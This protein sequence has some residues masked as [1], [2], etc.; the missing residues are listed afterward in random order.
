MGNS[1]LQAIMPNQNPIPQQNSPNFIQA[2]NEYMLAM[3]NPAKYIKDKFPD[4]PE[5]IQNDPNQILSYLQKT[6]GITNQQI[7]QS[8]SDMTNKVPW[9]GGHS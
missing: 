3:R 6:R 8:A 1:I 4:I 7:Q 2:M 9:G 5:N